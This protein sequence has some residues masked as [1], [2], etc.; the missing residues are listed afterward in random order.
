LRSSYCDPL[1]ERAA[2][3]CDLGSVSSFEDEIHQA[4]EEPEESRPSRA[5]HSQYNQKNH[6]YTVD[7]ISETRFSALEDQTTSEERLQEHTIEQQP[8]SQQEQDGED[9]DN[10]KAARGENKGT[11]SY[12]QQLKESLQHQ[13]VGGETINT[14]RIS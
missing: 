1:N 4:L 5:S 12:H 6:R 11:N 3:S 8:C 13:D 2:T 9:E 10:I 7:T 14:A